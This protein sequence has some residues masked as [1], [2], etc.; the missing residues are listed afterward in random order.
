MLHCTIYEWITEIAGWRWK[1]EIPKWTTRFAYFQVSVMS[2]MLNE[3]FFGEVGFGVAAESMTSGQ[4]HGVVARIIPPLWSWISCFWS[5]ISIQTIPEFPWRSCVGSSGQIHGS[6]MTAQC[7]GSASISSW[8]DFQSSPL[9][10]LDILFSDSRC[11]NWKCSMTWHFQKVC[12]VSITASL[13]AN[14]STFWK[15]PKKAKL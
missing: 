1:W 4:P 9:C 5:R 8:T 3:N 11:L 10:D 6:W 14:L 13:R 2:W 15:N 12:N 7:C